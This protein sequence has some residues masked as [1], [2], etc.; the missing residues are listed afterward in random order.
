MIFNNAF[1]ELNHD[2]ENQQTEVHNDDADDAVNVKWPSKASWNFAKP[3]SYKDITEAM[4]KAV[5]SIEGTKRQYCEVLCNETILKYCACFSLPESLG[6]KCLR[7]WVYEA[8][9]GSK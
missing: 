5:Q 1:E 4:Q 9:L 8:N 6:S 3:I 7:A 2:N